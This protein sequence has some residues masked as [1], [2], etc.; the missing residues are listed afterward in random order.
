MSD[1]NSDK[2]Q[3]FYAFA[4]LQERVD[5]GS[6]RGGEK[7]G[8][9]DQGAEIGQTPRGGVKQRLIFPSVGPGPGDFGGFPQKKALFW[10]FWPFWALLGTP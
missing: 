1:T 3:V 5:F 2:I 9:K 4:V 10:P 7:R 8:K 6:F